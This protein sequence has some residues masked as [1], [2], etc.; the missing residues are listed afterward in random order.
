MKI[1][2][3]ASGET[4]EAELD[5][6]GDPRRGGDMAPPWWLCCDGDQVGTGVGEGAGGRAAAVALRGESVVGASPWRR[7]E[8]VALPPPP[9]RGESVLI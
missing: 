8:S 1:A 6:V 5:S 4:L 3:A 9:L 2:L 7:G